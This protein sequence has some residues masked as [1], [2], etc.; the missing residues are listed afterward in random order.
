MAQLVACVFFALEH[1]K[2]ATLVDDQMSMGKLKLFHSYAFV[3]RVVVQHNCAL[4]RRRK[5][6]Q[7]KYFDKPK[8]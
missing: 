8:R 3:E 4:G 7:W 6:A 2:M 1:K 5:N